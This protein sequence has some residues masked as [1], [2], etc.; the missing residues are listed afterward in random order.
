MLCL[1]WRVSK[2]GWDCFRRKEL[3]E[4][5]KRGKERKRRDK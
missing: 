2:V 3:G 5:P 4:S 1:F